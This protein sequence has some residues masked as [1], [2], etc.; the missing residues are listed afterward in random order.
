MPFIQNKVFDPLPSNDNPYDDASHD[1]LR[2]Q[3]E[4]DD[5]DVTGESYDDVRN[6]NNEAGDSDGSDGLYDDVEV[7]NN[8]SSRA[9][10]ESGSG[11]SFV[12]AKTVELKGVGPAN[13][14]ENSDVEYKNTESERLQETRRLSQTKQESKH[15]EKVIF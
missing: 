15:G 6:E 12:Q 2:R 3:Q 11:G 14:K 13:G 10:A 4:V 8:R 5:D 1:R 7:N 9:K